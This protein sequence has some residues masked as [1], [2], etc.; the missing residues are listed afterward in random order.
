MTAARQSLSTPGMIMALQSLDFAKIAFGA[1]LVETDG[2]NPRKNMAIRTL[3]TRNGYQYVDQR[4]SNA[5]FVHA[6]FDQIY[7]DVVHAQ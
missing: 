2:H 7:A 5:W 3:L 4:G 6:E 1:I